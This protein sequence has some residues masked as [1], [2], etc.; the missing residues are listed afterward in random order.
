MKIKI[1]L[2]VLVLFMMI[3]SSNSYAKTSGVVS[4]LYTPESSS[5]EPSYGVG[6]YGIHDKNISYY[7]NLQFSS[8]RTS[9]SENYYES[10]DIYSFGD[11]V[12]KRFQDNFV[13]NF[14]I[15]KSLT[16]YFSGYGGLGF[17]ILSG[18]AKKYDPMH[19]LGSNG[20]YYVPD[21]ENDESSINFNIGTIINIKK[22]CIDIGYNSFRSDMYFGLGWKF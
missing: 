13:F 14:G 15:T 4:L 8:L 5:Y 9:D 21:D 7:I 16:K 10:L 2:V 22:V 12:E 19:I 20:T 3:G 11:P 17:S 6:I 1:L 18:V